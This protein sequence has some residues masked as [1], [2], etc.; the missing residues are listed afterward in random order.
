M[1]WLLP[2]LVFALSANLDSFV[3]GVTYGLRQVRIGWLPNTIISGI[4]FA[5]TGASL[6]VGR[7]LSTALPFG[8]TGQLGGIVLTAIGVYY[9]V[10]WIW[11]RLRPARPTGP[12]QPERPG[13]G[14]IKP[15]EAVVLGFALTIN[16]AGL[17]L[18]AG[19]ANLNLIASEVL[20]TVFSVLSLVVGSA[21]GRRRLAHWFGRWAEP[22]AGAVI[23][24]VGLYELVF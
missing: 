15:A 8:F 7:W 17:G 24:L 20:T 21:L 13:A 10:R 16:N 6:L 3:V 1:D 4:A 12:D 23:V 18:G 22:I 19:L 9:F 14:T 11:R 5:C 2:A